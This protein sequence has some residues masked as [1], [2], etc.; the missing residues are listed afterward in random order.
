MQSSLCT[1]IVSWSFTRK[2]TRRSQ[3]QRL[4][5]VHIILKYWDLLNV[6]IGARQD[7]QYPGVRDRTQSA[8]WI[9]PYNIHSVLFYIYDYC[10]TLNKS[11]DIRLH[12]IGIIT[13]STLYWH[14]FIKKLFLAATAALEVQMLVCLCVCVSVTLATAVQDFW[15][16]PKNSKGLQRTPKDF[17]RTSE[18][19]LKDF[20][21]T[22]E[23]L[24][25]TSEGF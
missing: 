9:Q 8:D 11:N 14:N 23:G 16:T 24:Q 21:R 22:S 3:Q 10:R 18:G 17:W 4:R 13:F 2:Y 25:R 5:N 1:S 19:L 20:W 6:Y 15:R 12:D 7:I